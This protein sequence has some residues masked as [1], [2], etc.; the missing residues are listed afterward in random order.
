MQDVRDAVHDIEQVGGSGMVSSRV[1][2]HQRSQFLSMGIGQIACLGF[3][4][5]PTRVTVVSFQGSPAHLTTI[6]TH[7]LR[8]DHRW[9]YWFS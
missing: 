8:R 2:S 4:A 7:P 1:R 3:P 9:D 6:V 5:Y